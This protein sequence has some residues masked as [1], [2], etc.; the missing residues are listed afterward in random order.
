MVKKGWVRR[1]PEINSDHYLVEAKI[2]VK[3][4][5]SG[6]SV[7]ENIRTI[8]YEAI[9]RYN[10]RIK[11]DKNIWWVN[12]VTT[13]ICIS[14]LKV[15]AVVEEMKPEGKWQVLKR[16]ILETAKEVCEMSKKCSNKKQIVWWNG[17]LREQIGE[18]KRL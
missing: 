17:E 4:Q 7:P 1:G 18:K 16:I 15:N 13:N 6:G 11:N 12:T 14:R 9:Q 5:L 3:N 10:L 8:E 2:S